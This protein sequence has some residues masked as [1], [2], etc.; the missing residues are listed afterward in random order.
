MAKVGEYGIETLNQN[1]APL[2]EIL[3]KLAA[4]SQ[5]PFFTPGH[6]RGQG[7]ADGLLQWWGRDIFQADLPELPELDNLLAP[8]GVLKQAQALAAAAFGASETWFL[9]NGSTAG[10]LAAMLATCGGGDKIVLPRNVH[11]SVISGLVLS[12]AIPVFVRPEYD[13]GSEIAGGVPLSAVAAALAEYPDAK[14]VMLVSPTYY[15]VASDVAAIADL[16]HE[17]EIPLLVDEAHGAHFGFHGSLPT[18]AMAAGADLAV[19]ST[20]KVLG[21]MTQ[22]AMLHC[23]YDRIDR[24]RLHQSLAM[25]QSSSPSYILLATLDAARRQMALQGEA[26]MD[27]ALELSD[28]AATQLSQVAGVRV[29]EPTD[30]WIRD[31]TRVT[32]DVSQLF[33]NGYDVD[34]LLHE[35]FGVTCE[36]PT[37]N[38]LMFLIT[39]GNTAE[40]IERLV[41]AVAGVVSEWNR[42]V[43]K[44]GWAGGSLSSW[45]IP[46][47]ACSPQTAFYAA[48][49]TVSW[50]A[51]RDRISA[52]SVCPYPP[53]IPLLIPGEVISEEVISYL[54]QVQGSGGTIVGCSDAHQQTL[55]VL[56]AP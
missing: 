33:R 38:H 7:M 32:V 9:V 10:I 5:A 18:S 31:R 12:G 50:H 25:V 21:A 41:Y 34:V 26:L 42:E 23:Q 14:A 37:L 53:G 30:F 39:F 55:E 20:H 47:L 49:E 56:A 54:Q 8:S 13:E 24:Q 11:Q 19:Q 4:R 16:V 27:R 36:L 17:Y 28:R 22:A 1:E 40:D 6:K 52:V 43:D 46:E 2:V 29:W 48:K 35:R 51:A 45:P 15:G 3:Q 44:Q